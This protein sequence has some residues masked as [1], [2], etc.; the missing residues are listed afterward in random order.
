MNRLT[1]ILVEK[2]L[3]FHKISCMSLLLAYLYVAICSPST[4][5]YPLTTPASSLHIEGPYCNSITQSSYPM[6]NGCAAPLTAN[7]H[8]PQQ[9]SLL[10]NGIGGDT[11][12]VSPKDAIPISL[13][14]FSGPASFT[15]CASSKLT[16]MT[17]T[18]LPPIAS[19]EPYHEIPRQVYPFT[20]AT[21]IPGTLPK[22][23]TPPP[24]SPHTVVGGESFPITLSNRLPTLDDPFNPP[25]GKNSIFMD[26]I[27]NFVATY[28]SLP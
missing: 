17:P 18:I 4:W 2:K 1:A 8:T 23:L 13:G 19:I 21:P 25:F 9:M 28:Q 12:L 14:S 27:P 22:L 3:S 10:N 5:Q 20:M 24:P 6:S 11:K 15:A 16:P 7:H 26:K